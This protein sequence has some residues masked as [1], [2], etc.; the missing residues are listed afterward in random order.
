MS[1]RL[2]IGL[3]GTL[4]VQA[5]L[6]AQAVGGPPSCGSDFYGAV[7]VA[8]TTA[9]W[10]TGVLQPAYA[11]PQVQLPATLALRGDGDWYLHGGSKKNK[12]INTFQVSGC[13]YPKYDFTFNLYYSSRFL[14]E[15]VPD[16]DIDPYFI[17]FDRMGSMPV[18]QNT[19][20]FRT[21]CGGEDA[22]D[23][24]DPTLDSPHIETDADNYPTKSAD[25]TVLFDNYGGC[26]QDAAGN[27]YV[28]RGMVVQSNDFDTDRL[29][30]IHFNNAS[31][32]ALQLN[33]D[34]CSVTSYVRVYHPDVNT[35]VVAPEDTSDLGPWMTAYHDNLGTGTTSWTFRDHVSVP[36]LIAVK[37]MC[38]TG[39][40]QP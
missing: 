4:V 13:R 33:C 21:F 19:T 2:L 30:L 22:A 24:S 9:D 34:G 17:H 32:G 15:E 7:W 16:H 14:V 25:G 23:D 37:R 20:T 28:R 8:R 29:S 36:F 1:R 40:C 27:Y 5:W 26:F 35:W 6:P 3:L 39:I 12:I 11:N 18:T 31:H 10:P 38:G